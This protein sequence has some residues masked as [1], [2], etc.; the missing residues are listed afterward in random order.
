MKFILSALLL[1]LVSCS[2]N[3][4][5]PEPQPIPPVVVSPDLVVNAP[6]ILS[7][8]QDL[9]VQD[10]KDYDVVI[11]D[12]FDT[13]ES[14]IRECAKHAL[15]GCYVSS[16]AESWRPDYSQFLPFKIG[17]LDNWDDE[18]WVDIRQAGVLEIMKARFKKAKSKG[19]EYV[20]V[21]NTDGFLHAVVKEFG[22]VMGD[23]IKFINNMYEEAHKLGLMYSLKNSVELIPH[24]KADLYQNESC[25]KYN[26][27]YHY[28]NTRKPVYNIEY[29]WSCKKYPYM[30][31]INGKKQMGSNSMNRAQ[32]LCK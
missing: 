25:Q 32:K 5:K 22:L 11:V 4:P 31:S 30:Y 13:K 12:M 24:V 10:C 9:T 15:M 17:D 23:Y 14:F 20:D 1:F 21:D 27:C 3:Q 8:K 7:Y 2:S 29:S 18:Y 26:E 6:T 16:Q 28:A 19:C